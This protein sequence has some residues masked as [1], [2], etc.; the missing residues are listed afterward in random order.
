MPLPAELIVRRTDTAAL[1]APPP[2]HHLPV[3]R[4]CNPLE[5][6]LPLPSP[7]A[8]LIFGFLF[9][10]HRPRSP[11][12]VSFPR[13]I[14]SSPAQLCCYFLFPPALSPLPSLPLPFCSSS[15]TPQICVPK[16]PFAEVPA[17]LRDHP[18]TACK[19]LSLT[20]KPKIWPKSTSPGFSPG[21][22]W[23]P[24]DWWATRQ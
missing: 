23:P 24:S 8:S 12:R 18:S 5:E 13:R 17:Q 10:L 6:S 15:T 20:F 19:L 9:M 1:T 3:S 11:S 16:M 7:Q 21:A 4:T 14:A 2:G 22:S